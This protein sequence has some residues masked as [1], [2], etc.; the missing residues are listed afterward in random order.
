MPN[1]DW[2][3]TSAALTRSAQPSPDIETIDWDAS[4]VCARSTEDASHLRREYLEFS[5]S[6]PSGP[7]H[8]SQTRETVEQHLKPCQPSAGL[9]QAA[10]TTWLRAIG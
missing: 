10:Q 7:G 2:A 9:R 8:Y 5:N 6:G 1:S 4:A 3:L